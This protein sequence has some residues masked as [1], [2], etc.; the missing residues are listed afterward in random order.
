MCTDICFREKGK[1]L[2][3]YLDFFPPQIILYYPYAHYAK[4]T[5]KSTEPVYGL[6]G[7]LSVNA[8]SP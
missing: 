6:D 3:V 2:Y 4:I 1:S 5:C 8:L 7:W